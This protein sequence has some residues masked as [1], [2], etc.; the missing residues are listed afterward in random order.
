MIYFIKIKIEIKSILLFLL[1]YFDKE[2]ASNSSFSRDTCLIYRDLLE[3]Q[4]LQSTPL[5]FVY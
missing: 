2:S 1:N 5:P 4:I 3:I